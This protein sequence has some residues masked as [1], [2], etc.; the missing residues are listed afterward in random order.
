MLNQYAVNYPTLPVNLRFS[1][2]F[3]DPGGMLSRS[4][5]MPSAKMG[6][7]VLGTHM[8]YRET[9]LEIQRRLLQHLFCKSRT[10]GVLMYQDTHHRM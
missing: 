10:H 1:H 3:R 6:R 4:L 2:L 5:G 8:V 7:Q 9:F